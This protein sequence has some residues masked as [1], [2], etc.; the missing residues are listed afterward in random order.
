MCDYQEWRINFISQ[1]TN[2]LH[3]HHAKLGKS[4]IV[5]VV[6]GRIV[7]NKNSEDGHHDDCRPV[8]RESIDVTE[9]DRC[10]RTDVRQ[11]GKRP[12]EAYAAAV[13]TI[14]KQFKTSAEQ[15]AVVSP[16]PAFNEIRGSLYCHRSRQNI[17]VPDPCD[18]PEELRSNG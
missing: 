6:E 13:G 17:P 10:M 16:F 15:T 8:A 3:A 2:F 11:T 4:R 12:R 9:I 7:D 14:P 18:I 5:T 1:L